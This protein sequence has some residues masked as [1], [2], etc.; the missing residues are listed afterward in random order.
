MDIYLPIADAAA[1]AH[2][3]TE[4]L[5]R[6]IESGRIKPAML[7]SGVLLVKQSDIPVR[8][9]DTAEYQQFA[10]LRGVGI[11]VRQAG[12][13]Y[14]VNSETISGWVKRGLIR[15][16]SGET[17]RGQR[18]MIDES[19]VAYCAMLYLRDPGQGKRGVK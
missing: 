3:T 1:A 4:E 14:G 5:N 2:L 7:A 9:D 12:E 11:G 15:R 16:L 19:D 6:L 18:V 10:H 13:K 17:L 8:R